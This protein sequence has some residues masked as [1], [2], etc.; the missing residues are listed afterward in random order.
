MFAERMTKAK[1]RQCH[2]AVTVFEIVLQ[3]VTDGIA[4]MAYV[5]C[6]PDTADDFDPTRG[7][8]R[9]QTP[10]RTVLPS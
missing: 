8:P 10:W 4:G 6:P 5:K 1:S 2:M 3:S 7:S 9:V